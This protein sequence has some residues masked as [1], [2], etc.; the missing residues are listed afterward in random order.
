MT[1][2]VWDLDTGRELRTLQGHSGGVNGVA[3]SPDGRHAVSA[4]YDNTL[5]VWDLETGRELRTLE[6][7]S[8]G[9]VES[10]SEAAE[11]VCTGRES[12]TS[13]AKAQR[14]LNHLRPD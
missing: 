2:K 8:G 7:H 3:I 10:P 9:S 1:L 14:I 6:G 12:N 4:S 5:K 13:G 11:K